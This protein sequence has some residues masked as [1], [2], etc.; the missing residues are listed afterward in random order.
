MNA[1]CVESHRCYTKSTLRCV[2]YLLEVY[3]DVVLPSV[4]ELS[5][6]YENKSL[7]INIIYGAFTDISRQ[8]TAT[9]ERELIFRVQQA[10]GAKRHN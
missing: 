5:T 4:K 6:L 7:E 2:G 9:P 1:S 8:T 10:I 3:R